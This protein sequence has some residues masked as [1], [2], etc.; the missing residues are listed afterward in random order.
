[1]GSHINLS[2]FCRFGDLHNKMLESNYQF[3][4]LKMSDISRFKFFSPKIIR[5][6]NSLISIDPSRN[7]V[8]LCPVLYLIKIVPRFTFN[9]L[10][11]IKMCFPFHLV[12]SLAPFTFQI[13]L[14]SLSPFFSYCHLSISLLLCIFRLL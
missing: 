1:V 10:Q 5:K 4:D 7:M 11:V 3:H 14:Q 12:S 13:C 2:V 9:F 6:F 8:K